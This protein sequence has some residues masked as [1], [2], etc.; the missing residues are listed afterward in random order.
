MT[1]IPAPVTVQVA[2]DPPYPVLIGTGLLGELGDLLA[3]RH[4]VA[5]LYQPVLT[6][7]AEAIRSYLSD[8]GI[9]AHR[10][11]IPDAEDGKDLPVVGFVWDVLGRIGL[12]RADALVSLGGG[13]ATDVAG[14]VAATWMRGVSIV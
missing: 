7:T 11:E 6:E 4:R 12:G 1:D 13:A 2:V 10:I 5:I 9:D 3:G 8:K 14:F